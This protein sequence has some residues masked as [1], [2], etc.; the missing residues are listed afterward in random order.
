MRRS[1]RRKKII[2][3]KAK[4]RFSGAQKGIAI[5]ALA[6]ATAIV[7]YNALKFSD[8]GSIT[9]T[10]NVI[11]ED[12]A[13]RGGDIV[14]SDNAYEQCKAKT[15]PSFVNA[16]LT[17][18]G[19]I[20][21]EALQSLSP[22]SVVVVAAGNKHPDPIRSEKVKAS[23][24]FDAIIVGS[25]AP[26]GQRSDFSHTHE[27]VHIMAPADAYQS[28]ADEDGNRQRFGGTSGAA[29]LVTGGLAGF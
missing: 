28:S 1:L 12:S 11:S 16:S 3:R 8:I 29:P 21:G 10:S 24:D 25:M 7:G 9:P 14:A 19:S 23:E 18:S 15:L 22:P 6:A 17:W 4:K 27:E 20:F 2:R 26:D 13:N 5:S